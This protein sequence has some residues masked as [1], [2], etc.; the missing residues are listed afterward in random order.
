MFAFSVRKAAFSRLLVLALIAAITLGYSP[1]AIS[2][3]SVDPIRLLN[4][5]PVSN[6]VTSGYN[7]ELFR[8]W[9]DLDSDGCDT[10]E[11]VLIDEKVAG[12]V[13]GC[14]VVNGKWVSQ[15]DGVTTTNSSNFD[16]DHFV[17][18]KEAW[19]S[20]AW[21]WD[22]S[23][24]ERFANDQGYALSLI[25]VSASS[26]RSKSDRD[27]SDW[28]PSE[29][30]CLY[31]KSWVGVKFRWRLSVDSREKTKLR[32]LLSD[33]KGTMKVPPRAQTTISTNTVP[34][35]SNGNSSLSNSATDPRFET[36]GQAIAAG[37]GPY[38]KGI[39]A[40]YFW[41]IDRDKDGSVCE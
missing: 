36:C 29:N 8:H 4:S 16:I 37:Y 21:R 31:A 12:T 2:A 25:A 24:R 7:R 27:P 30:L 41:Y 3:S 15:Y 39:D 10:R 11:E 22:S 6:E 1:T 13:V 18:L 32:Q 9:S 38:T 28:L 20:G 5:L 40:E 26:N 19:D 33:C 17:P 35:D 34:S 23:T 14:K